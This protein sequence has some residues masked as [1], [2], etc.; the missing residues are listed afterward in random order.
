MPPRSDQDSPWKLVLRQYFREAMEFFFPTIA[1]LVDW[2]KPP[3]FLD[4]EFQ[5]LAPDAAIGKRYADQLVRLQRQQGQPLYLL[6]HLEVQAAPD[7][8]PPNE[9]NGNCT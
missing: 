7:A 9:R 5:Q 4:K 8:M 3:E 1:E 6:L 2:T